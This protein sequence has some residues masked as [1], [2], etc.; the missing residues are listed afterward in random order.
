MKGGS[1]HFGNHQHADAGSFQIFYRGDLAAD[2]GMYGFYGTPY[3]LGFNKRSIAH[4]VMLVYDPAEKILHGKTN[5]GGQRF[6]QRHP[7][8]AE[9]L[10]KDAYFNYGST[11]SADFGPD[12]VRPYY[13]YLKSDL[14]AAYTDKIS[15]YTRTFCFLNLDNT[16]TPA[17]LIVLD[18]MTTAKPEF[19]KY[20]LLNTLTKPAID[21]KNFEVLA[22]RSLMPGKLA[23]SMLL[24][25]DADVTTRGGAK[26]LHEFFGQKLNPPVPGAAQ[27]NGFRTMVTPKAARDTDLFLAVMRISGEEVK[28]LP[29]KMAENAENVVLSLADRVVVLGTSAKFTAKAFEFE[30]GTARPST[31]VLLADLAPGVWTVK[32][33]ATAVVLTVEAGKNTAWL[34]LP[35]GR[36]TVT[37]GAPAVPEAVNLSLGKSEVA[38]KRIDTV[39]NRVEGKELLAPAVEVL[40][41]LGG[42]A[43]AAGKVLKLTLGKHTAEFKADEAA[44]VYDGA[45]MTMRAPARLDKGAWL[46]PVYVLAGIGNALAAADIETRSAF[47]F[48]RKTPSD[49]LWI[50]SNCAFTEAEWEQLATDYDGK[51][52]YWAAN[53][54]N[55]VFTVTFAEPLKL[56]AIG[57]RWSQGNSRLAKFKLEVSD[58]RSWK[59]VY[60]GES[61][62]TRDLELYKFPAQD[63]REIRFTGNGNSVN[64]WN[65]IVSFVPVA[66]K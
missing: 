46:V 66:A 64:S 17:A 38:G 32:G 16:A 6:I 50:D 29:V 31:Q 54:D 52:Q 56:E 24:P 19:K 11:L 35:A 65:S 27:A 15:Y 63:V 48:P 39:E 43:E 53:G 36:Y 12:S 34:E 41:L 37:P 9:M 44:F 30:V 55:R 42:K 51:S 49:I 14:K 33:G 20:F 59:T 5:D 21:G 4:N 25:Q 28:P 13:T 40:T 57:I 62:K 61:F 22:K 60:D 26:E 18:R 47:F 45:P 7:V 2:L 10:E 3:D 8:N 23:V 1:K 58:G